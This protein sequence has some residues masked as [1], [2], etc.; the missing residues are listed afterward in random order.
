MILPTDRTVFQNAW[1]VDDLDVAMQKWINVMKVGPFF[2][3]E[4]G[5]N[6]T[7]MMYRGEPSELS[8]KVAMAQAGPVQIELIQPT[9]DKPCAYRDT[10]KPGTTGF[11]HMCVWT[12]DIDADSK[13]YA[14]LGI[15]T[16]NIG[17][18]GTAKF[19]Y[20]D[21]SELFGCMIEVLEYNEG[22]DAMFKRIAE[23][24]NSWD[25]KNPIRGPED[26]FS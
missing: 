21:T 25:G 5:P 22:A 23:L 10:V 24:G 18:A 16:A 17:N 2:L 4:H 14:D 6:L 13:Y 7:D 20:Y 26:L 11:H 12:Y 9:T 15:E 3:F 19:A 1:V 8:M